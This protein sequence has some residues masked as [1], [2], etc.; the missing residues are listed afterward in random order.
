MS[1]FGDGSQ[2]RGFSYIDDVAPLPRIVSTVQRGVSRSWRISA[3][4]GSEL[5]LNATWRDQRPVRANKSVA[6]APQLPEFVV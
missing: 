1:I 6:N 2:T 5:F 3:V 4:A